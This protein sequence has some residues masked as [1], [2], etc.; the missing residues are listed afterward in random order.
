M[1]FL[2]DTLNK[3]NF[4]LHLLDLLFMRISLLRV[5]IIYLWVA[6]AI[7]V[8]T[9]ALLLYCSWESFFLSHNSL[10]FLSLPKPG[11]KTRWGRR[12]SRGGGGGGHF[13]SKTPDNGLF[14]K[15]ISR[16]TP[17]QPTWIPRI[18][19]FLLW[20]GGWAIKPIVHKHC[21]NISLAIQG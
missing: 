14:L 12:G 17:I 16:V 10:L 20:K 4:F 1:I 19:V 21:S 9:R 8:K 2:E 13:L 7:C 6:M 15:I 5:Y 3:F 18:Q 11:T